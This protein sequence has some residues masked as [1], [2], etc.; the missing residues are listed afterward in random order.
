MSD[1]RSSAG[2]REVDPELFFP[3]PGD[4]RGTNQAKEIC[5]QCPVRRACLFE[6]LREEGGRAKEN[7]FGIRGGKTPGQRYAI[8]M[9]RRKQQRA[10][11]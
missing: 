3:T 7:R 6:A 2:C 1:W 9:T 8:Y 4:I 11:A 5:G 10:A